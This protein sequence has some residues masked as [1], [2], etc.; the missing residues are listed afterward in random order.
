MAVGDGGRG[1]RGAHR[2][3]AQLGPRPPVGVKPC[4]RL[5]GFQ[6]QKVCM[7]V[8]KCIEGTEDRKS[9]GACLRP[10][11]PGLGSP[12]GSGHAGSRR[13][14]PTSAQ[15]GQRLAGQQSQGPR[16]SRPRSARGGHG[17]PGS[18][19]TPRCRPGQRLR[20][21]TGLL[22]ALPTVPVD[23]SLPRVSWPQ[24]PCSCHPRGVGG[25]TSLCGGG[26]NLPGPLSPSEKAS[27]PSGTQGKLK[28]EGKV[29]SL[30]ASVCLPGKWA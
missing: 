23:A 17:A 14:G 30:R 19:S 22:Q 24:Q 20:E 13:E 1:N 28:P 6:G 29:C 11:N 26:P 2:A 27:R 16:V 12:R 25:G 3:S 7:Y 9:V 10:P 18:R 5:F 4:P 8:R 15:Q 21:D